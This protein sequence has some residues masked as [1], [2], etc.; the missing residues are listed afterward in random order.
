MRRP[1]VFLRN[2]GLMKSF[3]KFTSKLSLIF[4]ISTVLAACSTLSEFDPFSGAAVNYAAGAPTALSLS[5]QD[6]EALASAFNRAM[7]TGGAQAWSGSS[8][9][10][11]VEPLEYAVANLKAD[12]AARIQ[13]ARGD[14][15]LAQVMETEL[16]LYVLTRNSNIRLG[17]GADAKAVEVLP[18]GT[19]VEVVGR[20]NDRNWMLVAVG[21][22]IRGYVFGD[23]LIKAPGSELEL[24]GGPMRKPV[25]C[26]NFRQSVDI[27]SDKVEWRG[28]ACNDGTGWRLAPSYRTAEED[29][30]LTGL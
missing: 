30:E 2:A 20:V 14:I 24:A 5:G 28:A 8:A 16:G 3:I 10:G 21:D 13:A 26:R 25:L 29:D 12:P 7:T 18:S 9:R 23:L 22:I 1:R 4:A 11:V 17:P 19:G 6:Q 15:D 27:Y